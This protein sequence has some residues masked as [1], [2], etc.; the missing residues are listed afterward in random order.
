MNP[1]KA[2]QLQKLNDI[3]SDLRYLEGFEPEYFTSLIKSIE[4]KIEEIEKEPDV[5]E[6]TVEQ[7]EDLDRRL[8]SHRKGQ[9]ESYSWNEVKNRL[10]K[11]Q[12]I[13]EYNQ[14]IEEAENNIENG[15]FYTNDQLKNRFS[16]LSKIV[17]WW[18]DLTKEE[19]QEIEEGLKQIENGETITHK[20]V[21]KLFDKWNSK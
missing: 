4:H 11:R 15:R 16:K 18:D 12:T 6:L 20:N 3:L 8:E 2:I 17:D 5:F 1:H 21:M 19:Q 10:L 14:E 13:E 7:K 9:S